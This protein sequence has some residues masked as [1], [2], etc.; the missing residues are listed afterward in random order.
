MLQFYYSCL[1]L[2]CISG[3]ALLPFMSSH[4]LARNIKIKI[5]KTIIL[6]VVLYGCEIVTLILK[7]ENRLKCLGTP[8]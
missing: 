5:Y 6:P 4:L 2:H 8:C 7:E 1:Y 3:S